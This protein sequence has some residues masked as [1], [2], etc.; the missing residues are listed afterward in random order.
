MGSLL[1]AC[2]K[3]SVIDVL[4]RR[5]GAR[6]LQI[7]CSSESIETVSAFSAARRGDIGNRADGLSDLNGAHFVG[8]QV[9]AS[10][11]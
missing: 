11:L 9:A 10:K 2:Q 8:V 3:I 6:G 5:D 7:A 1:R 4:G